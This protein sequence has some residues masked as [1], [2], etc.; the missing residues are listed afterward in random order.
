M[1]VR[2]TPVAIELRSPIVSRNR[3]PPSSGE[4]PNVLGRIALSW[5]ATG[6]GDLVLTTDHRKAP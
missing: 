3:T 5:I 2:D 1:F 6:V 4:P